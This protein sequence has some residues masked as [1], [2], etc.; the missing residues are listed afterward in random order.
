[1]TNSGYNAIAHKPLPLRCL[2]FNGGIFFDDKEGQIPPATRCSSVSPEGACPCI[3][4]SVYPAGR[5]V[6][7]HTLKPFCRAGAVTSCPVL[8]SARAHVA[9]CTLGSTPPTHLLPRSHSWPILLLFLD[10]GCI[11]TLILDYAADLQESFSKGLAPAVS[12][13]DTRKQQSERGVT[14]LPRFGLVP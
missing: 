12:R 13:S 7:L 1:M 2:K 11:Y 8:V 10:N 9:V 5:S 4:S 6:S 3:H 14:W